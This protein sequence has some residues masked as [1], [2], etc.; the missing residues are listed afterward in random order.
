MNDPTIASDQ[1]AWLLAQ[2]YNF[3]DYDETMYEHWPM[4]EPE[5]VF[6]IANTDF[7]SRVHFLIDKKSLEF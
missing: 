2:D 3:M 6:R 4:D 1:I 7:S 5:A